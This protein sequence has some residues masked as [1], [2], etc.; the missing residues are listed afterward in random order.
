MKK[1]PKEFMIMGCK[2]TIQYEKSLGDNMGVTFP[3]VGLIK[4]IRNKVIPQDSTEATLF[5]E[6]AHYI[7]YIMNED[8]HYRSEKFVDF[9]GRIM[10]Q[11]WLTLK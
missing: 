7:L 5:H 9:L 11:I 8:K 1:L 4:V 10:H 2:V 6:I 3:D